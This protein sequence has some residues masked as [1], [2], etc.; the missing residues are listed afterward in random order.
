MAAWNIKSPTDIRLRWMIRHA[1][2]ESPVSAVNL[3]KTNV[4]S[5][6]GDNTVKVQSP[7]LQAGDYICGMRV[8]RQCSKDFGG[9]YTHCIKQTLPP[10]HNTILSTEHLMFLSNK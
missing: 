8:H 2:P 7:V 5:G 3:S 9:Y 10:L 6:A 4:F 1:H